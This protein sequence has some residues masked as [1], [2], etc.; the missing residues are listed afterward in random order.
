MKSEPPVT[1]DQDQSAALRDKLLSELAELT[2]ADLATLWARNALATK[3]KL[4]TTDAACVEDAFEQ[5]VA[6]LDNQ[7]DK[8]DT[9]E[10]VTTWHAE[11]NDLLTQLDDVGID[12]ELQIEFRD[13]MRKAGWGGDI[14]R[15]N[16]AWGRT[17]GGTYAAP[18]RYRLLLSRAADTLR[19][20]MQEYLLGNTQATGDEP[21]Q[22]QYQDLVDRYYRVLA[23]EGK[24][25]TRSRAADSAGDAAKK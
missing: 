21:I 10:R 6:Q 19:A 20:R 22:P 13:E 12:K 25:A 7:L 24:E 9:E 14:A 5:K 8:L 3:N 1:L 15:S 17:T 2:T 11:A 16:W 4:T 23:A 18:T